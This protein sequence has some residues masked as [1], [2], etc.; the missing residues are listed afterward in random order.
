MCMRGHEDLMS[1]TGRNV[2]RGAAVVRRHLCALRW[3]WALKCKTSSTAFSI[4]RLKTL[5][6]HLAV[7]HDAHFTGQ[8]LFLTWRLGEVLDSAGVATRDRVTEP[9]VGVQIWTHDF[10]EKLWRFRSFGVQRSV[11]IHGRRE[12]GL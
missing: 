1:A 4:P 3:F 7:A 11:G 9:R 5:D 12:E 2:D 6:L 10:L 8:A